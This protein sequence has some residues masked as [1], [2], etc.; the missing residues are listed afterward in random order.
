MRGM[1]NLLMDFML[2][3]DF[4]HELFTKIAD[5]NIAQMEKLWSMTLMP[6]ILVTTGDSRAD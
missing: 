4:V 3:P 2:Y 6:F 5:Y 1:E